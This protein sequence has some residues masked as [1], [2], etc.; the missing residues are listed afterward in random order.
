MKRGKRV[1]ALI[2]TAVLLCSSILNVGAAD[3]DS[4]TAQDNGKKQQYTYLEDGT[5]KDKD[6]TEIP[7]ELKNLEQYIGKGRTLSEDWENVSNGIATLA[8]NEGDIVRITPGQAVSYGG[9]S[10][11]IF[12]VSRIADGTN[13][14][15]YCAQPNSSTPSG[16][17]NASKLNNDLIK[18]L[19]MCA[20]GGPLDG[21]IDPT[22]FPNGS[23]FYDPNVPG[24]NV[25][26]NAH[27]CIGWVY[28]RQTN[29]LSSSYLNGIYRMVNSAQ[30]VLNNGT[31]NYSSN[32]AWDKWSVYVARN[33]RQDIVW[34]ESEPQKGKCKVKKESANPEITNGNDCYNLKGAAYGIYRSADCS[35]SSWV[36]T[37]TTN[38]NGE[39]NTVELDAGTYYVREGEAPKGYVLD[40]TVQT[41]QIKAGE[42]Y[43]VK[44]KDAP[45]IN[46]ID[47]LLEKVDSETNQNKP[48]GSAS[49]EGALFTVKFYAGVQSD[50]DPAASGKTPT[51]TW[52]FRTDADGV[53]NYNAKYLESGDE[54]YATASGTQ[55]LPMGTVTI[56]E[57]KAPEGYLINSET[58]VMQI[59]SD[60]KGSEYV[61]TYNDPTIKEQPLNLNVVK[62]ENG[63][64]YAIEGVVFEHTLPD[65]TTERL[66]TDKNG[67]CSFKGLT[68]GKHTLREVSAPDEYTVNDGVITFTVA[69]DN[70]I[71]VDSN[72]SKDNTMKLE[73]KKSGILSL[74][75]EDKL[76]PY[77]MVATKVN[78]KGNVLEGAEF[79]LY[80]DSACS[81]E[82][83]KVTTD[84]N[85]SVKIP[86]LNVGTKY[87]LKETKA[88]E[89][90]RI[91][92]DKN[93][94]DY[95]Y[96]IY[97]KINDNREYE[98]YVNGQLHKETSGDYAISGT[99]HNREVN[100]TEVQLPETGTHATFI[101]T[102]IG[103]TMMLAAIACRKKI[104]K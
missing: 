69:K 96:E 8:M 13:R 79:T 102:L 76:Q 15:G 35:D 61:Y 18:V 93:G 27:A 59:T 65:G 38:E 104:K 77:T 44:A 74:L 73:V 54:L 63:K 32:A 17:Y 31:G 3:T 12:G 28:S 48:Q 14:I 16:N 95:I 45:T 81:K 47:V 66:T 103:I 41:V 52:V 60:N 80:T 4:K 88:P 33:S 49:L 92:K 34:L 39:S 11:N 24:G 5:A 71:T 36:A 58:H 26:A 20:P 100:Q 83:A 87:Y 25:Y 86:S 51:R 42:T 99:V 37:M 30:N 56:Q 64:D 1:I 89:G 2:G 46:P 91:P 90:Y 82:F 6:L 70:T 67:S 85:G 98:Y 101:I 53:V 68:Y 57:T 97:T 23:I 19:L 72:T 55:G 7:D 29:G 84:A 10:T 75:V 50:N 43:I 40:R 62:K 21:K 9:W 94:N 22:V 78:E